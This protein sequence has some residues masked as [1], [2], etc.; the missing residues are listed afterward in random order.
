MSSTTTVYS[1]VIVSRLAAVASRLY[2]YAPI[3]GHNLGEGCR[4]CPL[5]LEGPLSGRVFRDFY[6]HP[7]APAISRTG[8]DLGGHCMG[9]ING[10]ERLG[11]FYSK[12]GKNLVSFRD[13]R[14][15]LTLYCGY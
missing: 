4:A 11:F 3:D 7:L 1:H 15:Q 13:A 14:D 10:A 6:C 12:T 5:V 2:P 9:P 8:G